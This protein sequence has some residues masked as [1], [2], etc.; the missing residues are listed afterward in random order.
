MSDL[1]LGAGPAPEGAAPPG[2]GGDAEP[3]ASGP[4][5][6]GTVLPRLTPEEAGSAPRP[7]GDVVLQATGLN[8]VYGSGRRRVPVLSDVDVSLHAGECVAVMGRSGAGK[9][10]LLNLLGLL[11][12]PDGGSLRIRGT[13]TV[14]LGASARS[15]LRNREIG[16][17]FQFYH[18]I[19]E[20]TALENALLPQ[21]IAHGP[22]KWLK[23]KRAATEHALQLLDEMGLSERL[24]HRPS[25]LSGGERQRVAIARALVARPALMLCDEPTGNLD[26]RTSDTI[27]ELLFDLQAKHDVTLV[28]VTH[29]DELAERADRCLHLTE[30]SLREESGES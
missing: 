26:E 30:G 3:A 14:K 18:L 10:T 11:D 25:Q 16:F 5:H 27:T 22:L 29:D 17:V 8:R 9:S 1:E 15:A 24:R 7:R 12:K 21:M 13:E 6:A 20:L 4:G 28:L 2:V 23:H 19:A